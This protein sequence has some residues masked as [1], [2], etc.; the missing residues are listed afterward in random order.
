M[1]LVKLRYGST[2]RF[3]QSDTIP[4]A[5]VAQ[6][7]GVALSTVRA[8]ILRFH[9]AGNKFVKYKSKGRTSPIPLHV[10]EEMVSPEV[11]LAMRYLPLRK[12]AEKYSKKLGI[13]ITIDQLRNVYKKHQVRFR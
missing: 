4:Y 3:D 9:R 10:Q 11:L 2:R 8:C 1:R 13:P 7:S 5:E 6:R 12:R